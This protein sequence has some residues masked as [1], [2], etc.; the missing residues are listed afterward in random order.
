MY[1]RR[2]KIINKQEGDYMSKNKIGEI[3][4]NNFGSKIVITEYRKKYS[5]NGE[6]T[7]KEVL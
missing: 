2:V 4:Y 5:D 6:L 7:L 3:N 1:Y